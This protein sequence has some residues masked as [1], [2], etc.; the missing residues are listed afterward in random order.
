MI[1]AV[2][3]LGLLE[4]ENIDNV[5]HTV[6]RY[7]FEHV[8]LPLT[9][10]LKKKWQDI[11]VKDIEDTRFKI[12]RAGLKVNSL[13]SITYGLDFDICNLHKDDYIYLVKHF[14]QVAVYASMLGARHVVY[15]SPSTRIGNDIVEYNKFF[16]FI[17]SIFA[18]RGISFCLENN[19][20]IFNNNFGYE[21]EFIYKFIKESNIDNLYSHFDTGN[22][23]IESGSMP[24]PDYVKSIHISNN[25]YANFMKNELYIKYINECLKNIEGIESITME[26]MNMEEDYELV[27]NRFKCIVLDI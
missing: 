2:S 1:T 7:G 15:G 23:Y 25:K 24:N 10:I 17:S 20:R 18:K 5:L 13:Q 6:K 21:S 8:E 11:T 27:I 22:E 26:N 19:A 12:H 9:Y 16:D 3:L 4:E 14:D